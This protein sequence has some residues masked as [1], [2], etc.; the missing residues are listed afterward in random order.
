MQ[1]DISKI[2][3]SFVKSRI[4]RYPSPLIFS[5]VE[6]RGIPH[7]EDI[8]KEELVDILLEEHRDVAYDLYN[9][10]EIKKYLSEDLL[11]ER[12][13]DLPDISGGDAT[14]EEL[15][16]SLIK[17]EETDVLHDVEL[18]MSQERAKTYRRYILTGSELQ[19]DPSALLDR[20]SSAFEDLRNSIEMR[21][22][23]PGKMA[24]LERVLQREESFLFFIK[25]VD[26]IKYAEEMEGRH[27]DTLVRRVI[28]VLHPPSDSLEI[29]TPDPNRERRALYTLSS[30]LT[31]RDDSF[32]PWD[33]ST[34]AIVRSITDPDWESN[35]GASGTVGISY[36]DFVNLDLQG[37]P[38]KMSLLGDDVILTIRALT[39]EGLDLS[40]IGTLHK[41]RF[42]FKN[43]K[44]D[45]F[46]EDGKFIFLA[47]MDERQRR[48]FYEWISAMDWA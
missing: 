39:Q 41:I 25:Y 10:A 31:G 33:I 9:A 35:A 11:L 38:Q 24:T 29:G 37:R 28:A 17:N 1:E 7:P 14:R 5:F 32:A 48:E 22:T 15:V 44:I 36:A 19:F 30:F 23:L 26:K 16:L 6:S 34:S 40:R 45:L 13:A 43:R 20:E 12:V 8:E 42:V 47:Y 18:L 46:P 3:D 4:M 21:L 2:P 27:W